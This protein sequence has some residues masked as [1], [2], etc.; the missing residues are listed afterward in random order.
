MHTRSSAG[1][2]P[3]QLAAFGIGF[4]AMRL[5][6]VA[7]LVEMTGCEAAEAAAIVAGVAEADA[8]AAAA[9]RTTIVSG[10]DG[11]GDG[12]DSLASDVTHAPLTD[13]LGEE[14]ADKA[15]VTVTD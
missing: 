13:L 8:A 2:I 11:D 6:T 9:A 3:R 1:T 15:I 5:L 14:W 12:E 4:G 10:G 7:D